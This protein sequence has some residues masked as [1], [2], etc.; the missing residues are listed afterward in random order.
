MEKI[1]FIQSDTYTKE[2]DVMFLKGDC[3]K[4]LKKIPNDSIHL[5]VTSPPYNL[6]KEYEEKQN[7]NVYLESMSPIIKELFRIL[8]PEGSICW[9]V[10]NYVEKGE[11]FPLDILYYDIFKKYNFKLR[12]RIIWH[13][14]HG[15]H[16]RKRLSGRYETM[17]WF[18]KSDKYTF[19]LDKIR[20]PSKY[21][22][23]RNYKPGKNYGKPSGNPLGKNPSDYWEILINEWEI[24]FWEIPN[25]KSNHPEKTL[26]P[27]SFPIELVER[28]IFGFTNEQDI[29]LDPF[30]G[31][32]SAIIAAIMNNRK[33]I[34]CEIHEDYILASK[35]RVKMLEDGVLPYRPLGK[36]IHQPTGKEK[37]SQV[38]IEWEK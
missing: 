38:P 36:K 6:Q 20:I 37:V 19:N 7:L 18:T 9:Q 32:G 30:S 29:V 26:H 17:L 16:G 2:S 5:I 13:F 11:I 15:L 8:H 35:K 27:C 1:K 12:N 21:P 14:N 23:K 34:G 3:L 24:G 28:C 4:T 22:G 25:V 31:V 10:G 33:A